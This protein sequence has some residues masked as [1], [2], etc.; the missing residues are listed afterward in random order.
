VTIGG[1]NVVAEVYNALGGPATSI[2]DAVC[3]LR[4]AQIQGALPCV[5]SLSDVDAALIVTSLQ[6]SNTIPTSGTQH[7]RVSPDQHVCTIKGGYLI[8]NSDYV[9][10]S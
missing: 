5:A 9:C 6:S 3:C 4:A 2:N 7:A 1:D 10:G 8:G